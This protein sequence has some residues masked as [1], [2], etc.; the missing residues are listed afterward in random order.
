V[1]AQWSFDERPRSQDPLAQWA[2]PADI[3]AT[4]LPRDASAFD[5]AYAAALTAAR[6]S[7]DLTDLFACLEH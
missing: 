5:Q 2:A 4:L 7:L 6:E 1:T 3:R